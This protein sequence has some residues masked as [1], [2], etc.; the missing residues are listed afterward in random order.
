MPIQS[1]QIK[2]PDGSTSRN[3]V[4]S[5]SYNRRLSEGG[6]V[7]GG[8]GTNIDTKDIAQQAVNT[9]TPVGE[10]GVI[11]SNQGRNAVQKAQDTEQ[12]LTALPKKEAVQGVADSFQAETPEQQKSVQDFKDAF[13]TYINQETGQEQTLKGE[14]LTREAQSNL[15]SQGYSLAESNTSTIQDSPEVEQAKKEAEKATKEL[16]GLRS[17]ITS[18]LISDSELQGELNAISGAFDAQ[19]QEMQRI[20]ENRQES[21]RT[22]GVRIGSR[23]SGG[24]GGVIGSIIAEEQRQGI[25]RIAELEAQKQAALAGAKRAAK[26]FNFALYTQEINRAEDQQKQKVAEVQGLMQAQQK[27]TEALQAESN[28]IQLEQNIAGLMDQGI[29][30]PASLQAVLGVKLKDIQSVLDIIDPSQDM[31]GL[32]TDYR[33]YKTMQDN[34][35]ISKDMGYTGYLAM[36]A[37]AKRKPVSTDTSN[38]VT[39]PV[40]SFESFVQSEAGNIAISGVSTEQNASFLKRD[41][42]IIEQYLTKVAPTLFQ[43]GLTED[44]INNLYQNMVSGFGLEE[45]I[46]S[47][48]LTDQQ[49]GV[50]KQ[51][52][53][54]SADP[55]KD[56]DKNDGGMTD[57]QFLRLLS[58]DS[59]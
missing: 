42:A 32:S 5:K 58:G 37:N 36:V 14:A 13:A 33:T 16:N 7:V 30:D 45:V 50:L 38:S 3:E 29:T 9:T 11:S 2:N 56:T 8:T 52:A 47:S 53:G 41:P 51:I 54:I 18:L 43:V 4:G 22:L 25:S 48:D 12:R 59:E 23:Y 35:E 19:Q 27:Y 44:D 46:K 10:V 21:I 49:E 17:K 24:T 20:N 26:E 1:V 34:G 6:S 15:E 57:E 28:Q 40:D 39:T 31:A 55:K